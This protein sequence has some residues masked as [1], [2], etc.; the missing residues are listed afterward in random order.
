M[1]YSSFTTI[2]LQLLFLSGF[3]QKLS[4]RLNK[5]GMCRVGWGK[6]RDI[7]DRLNNQAEESRTENPKTLVERSSVLRAQDGQDQ[8]SIRNA[9]DY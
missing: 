3:C 2:R 4:I 1:S 9:N 8:R 6:T 5:Q 7:L